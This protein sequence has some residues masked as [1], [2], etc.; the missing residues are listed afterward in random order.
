M[1][2]RGEKLNGELRR[3]V[4][5]QSTV[6]FALVMVFLLI[7]LLVGLIDVAR[8]YS[9]QLA[10][11]NAAKTGARWA[12]LSP[13]Q[14][15]DSGFCTMQ[16]VINADLGPSGIQ[17]VVI[18]PTP[19]FT[20]TPTPANQTPTVMPTPTATAPAVEVIIQYRH[21]LLLGAGGT[22]LFIGRAT[23]PGKRSTP[24]SCPTSTPTPP[25]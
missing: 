4:R 16:D 25:P 7:P 15:A 1:S 19:T 5:G 13:D 17:Y 24:S 3:R 6:E 2:A 11:V 22:A 18:T 9:E 8:V 20:A 23:M 21:Q 10:I 12:V 14:Q